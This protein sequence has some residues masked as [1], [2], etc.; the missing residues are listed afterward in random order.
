MALG[1]DSEKSMGTV[2]KRK[3]LPPS[4]W[5]GPFP[6]V[7]RIWA[8]G[9][10]RIPRRMKGGGAIAFLPLLGPC[11]G[12]RGRGGSAAGGTTVMPSPRPALALGF[13]LPPISWACL[14]SISPDSQSGCKVLTTPCSQTSGAWACP[15]WSCPS[16]G[17]PS[18]HQMPRSWKPYLAGPW[19]MGRKESHTA[20]RHGRDPPDAPSAVWPESETP[21]LVGQGPTQGTPC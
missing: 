2:M 9:G 14:P 3:A 18:P 6:K 15:W 10:F 17:T 12:S 19:S 11:R 7:L 16:E 21:A 1:A 4:L 5:K 8:L 13:R 20:S